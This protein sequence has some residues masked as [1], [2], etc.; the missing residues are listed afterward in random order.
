MHKDIFQMKRQFLILAILFTSIGSVWADGWPR[1]KGHG[2]YKLDFSMIQARQ[3][4]SNQSDIID[5]NGVGTQL[6]SYVTSFY[7]EY[8]ITDRLTAVAYVPFLVRN[9]VNEG[10]G[11]LTG[12]VLQPGLENTAFGDAD[13]GLRYNFY[14]KGPWVLSGSLTLGLPTGDSENPDLLYTG[15]GEFNQLVKIEWGYGA[16]RWYATGHLGFNN[17]TEGFSEE[18][19]F[20]AE[21]GYWIRP[22]KLLLQGRVISNQTLNNGNPQ[23]SGTGLFANNVAFV[24]PQL[25]LVYEWNP[26]WGVVANAGFAVQGRNALAA[27]ALSFG[28]YTKL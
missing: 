24:S 2:F 25:G 11:E 14:S 22:S 15:D 19:R 26:N 1:P 23:G 8:G 17:R 5:L 28:V 18:W 3:F 13:L 12:E 7:G 20:M 27:P 16:A 10:V 6:G 4:F 21:A 9:T